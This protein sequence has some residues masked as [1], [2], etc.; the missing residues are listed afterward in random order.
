MYFF[1]SWKLLVFRACREKVIQKKDTI[2]KEVRGTLYG[3][4][5]SVD[6]RNQGLWGMFSSLSLRGEW[7]VS[8]KGWEGRGQKSRGKEIFPLTFIATLTWPLIRWKELGRFTGNLDSWDFWGT[9]KVWLCT[10]EANIL[11][12][13]SI[14]ESRGGQIWAGK[15]CECL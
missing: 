9:P 3:G 10:A 8:L 2:S 12:F 14:I 13:H 7:T 15:Q 11:I 5:M 1:E 6:E 4:K